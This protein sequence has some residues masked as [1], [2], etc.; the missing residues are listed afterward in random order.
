VEYVI[1]GN[2]GMLCS[3]DDPDDLLAGIRYV[4]DR[5]AYFSENARAYARAHLTMDRMVEGLVDAI[6]FVCDSV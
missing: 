1:H 5:Q 3:W 4:L 2:N 6:H